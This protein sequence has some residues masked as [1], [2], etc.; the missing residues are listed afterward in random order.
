M[1]VLIRSNHD[2][3]SLC[4]ARIVAALVREKPNAVLGLPT[5]STP[6]GTYKELIRMHREEG[7]DFSGVTT[8]NL[9]E[10][11]GIGKD[12]SKPYTEDQS[13]ARFMWE[14]FY[15][16]IEIP[17]EQTHIPDGLTKNPDASCVEYEEAIRQAGGIDLQVLGIGSNGHW[18]FNEPGTPLASRT[19]I[20]TL[21]Q[22]TLDDNWEL[23]YSKAGGRREDMPHFALTMGVGTILEARHIVM[24]AAGKRKANI[25]ARALEGPLTS[26]VTASAVQLCPGRVTVILDEKAATKLA[27]IDYYR[28]VERVKAQYH[29]ELG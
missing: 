20:V 21:T 26:Q 1:D 16:S 2:E 22:Q 29:T 17:P 11:L 9:D 18:G 6:I 27:N 25:V 4:A 28:H 14:E 19:H 10:Y 23:F 8:F 12:M 13:Y 24:L 7:L 5:G 3:M 15:K